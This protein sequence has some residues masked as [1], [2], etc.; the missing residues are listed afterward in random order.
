MLSKALLTA[1]ALLLA[2]SGPAVSQERCPDG[3][4]ASGQCVNPTL[5]RVM[6]KQTVIYTQPKFSYTAPLFLPNEGRFYTLGR[7]HHEISHFYG[8]AVRLGGTIVP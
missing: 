1:S 8:P 2:L 6:R 7:D 4:T 5:A 3:R